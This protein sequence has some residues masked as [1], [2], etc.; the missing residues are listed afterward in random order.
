LALADPAKEAN[1]MAAAA[2]SIKKILVVGL[3]ENDTDG[4]MKKMAE[5]FAGHHRLQ[6]CA[7]TLIEIRSAEA[8]QKQEKALPA[9]FYDEVIFAGHSCFIS[10]ANGAPLPLENRALGGLKIGPVADFIWHCVL[11]RKAKAISVMCCEVATRKGP[12]GGSK[13]IIPLYQGHLANIRRRVECNDYAKVSTLEYLSLTLAQHF[14]EAHYTGSVI[15]SGLNGVGYLGKNKHGQM[16]VAALNYVDF[17]LVK[18]VT[19]AEDAVARASKPK[20]KAAQ[21][22]L[23][24]SKEDLQKAIERKGTPV[25]SL[26]LNV[27]S[28]PGLFPGSSSAA[29]IEDLTSA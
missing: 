1:D 16:E 19:D 2:S 3:L 20:L 26:K 5:G 23:S 25:L 11:V 24:K 9:G 17:H 8:L 15:L 28:L 6:G 21:E 10:S 7:V 13:D 18:R 22:T 14:V 29:N 4:S 12:Y 27:D